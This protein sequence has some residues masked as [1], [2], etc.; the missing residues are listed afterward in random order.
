MSS[1]KHI[2][3]KRVAC[4]A[5]LLIFLLS[6]TG[7]D[8]DGRRL[9]EMIVGT[10]QRGWSA[11]DVVID[12]ETDLSPE[13]F[14]YDRFVFHDDGTYNGMMRKGTFEVRDVNGEVVFEG[15]YQCDNHNLK[16]ESGEG[17]GSRQ[18][19]LAQVLSF[20]DDTI[21]LQ[22]VNESY[23]VTVSLIIRKLPD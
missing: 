21:Q 7:G 15:N 12:G 22:Y 18:A 3:I 10:W 19:I 9:G 11:G 6:C 16:L 1:R 13:N 5:T 14:S 23:H 4:L 8:D 2:F 20:T 17:G